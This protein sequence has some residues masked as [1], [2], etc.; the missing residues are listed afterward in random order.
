M[1]V[2]SAGS[3]S[4]GDVCFVIIPKKSKVYCVVSKQRSSKIIKESVN[5]SFRA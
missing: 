5:D 3:K 4:E 1:N 2:S